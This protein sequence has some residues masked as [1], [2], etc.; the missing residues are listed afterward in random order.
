[1]ET[2]VETSNYFSGLTEVGPGSSGLILLDGH[3]N[4]GINRGH[5]EYFLASG[6]LVPS[7]KGMLTSTGERLAICSNPVMF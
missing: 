2:L 3:P 4:P 5:N 6:L 1:M 7:S